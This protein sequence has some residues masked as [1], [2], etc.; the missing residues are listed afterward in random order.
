VN[1]GAG[2]ESGIW[3]GDVIGVTQL[4][5]NCSGGAVRK[6]VIGDNNYF[7]S[8]LFIFMREIIIENI[9][10]CCYSSHGKGKTCHFSF[11]GFESL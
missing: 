11:H 7:I 9:I 1:I 2:T 10:I 5:T 6:Q 4:P 8:S 3:G